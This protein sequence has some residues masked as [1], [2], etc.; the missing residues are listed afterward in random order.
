M[1]YL[2]SVRESLKA[3]MIEWPIHNIR[4]SGEARL[5]LAQ[6]VD[7]AL[8]AAA[9]FPDNCNWS[10]YVENYEDL[11]HMKESEAIGHWIDHGIAEGRDCTCRPR[12]LPD[13]CNWKCYLDNYADLSNL[14][15]TENT[16]VSHYLNHGIDEERDCSCPA[17]FRAKTANDTAAICVIASEEEKYIDEWLDFHLGIGFNH[18]YVYDNTDGFD[19]GHGWLARRPRLAKKV[20]VHHFPGDGKQLSAYR[21]CLKNYVRPDGHGWVAFLDVDEFFMLKKHASVIEF[22]L[23]HCKKGSVSL[24]WQLFGYDERMDFS[25][26]PVTQRFQGQV[27][28]RENIH[29]KSISN[30]DAIQP[31]QPNNPHYVHLVYGHQQLDTNGDVV[32]NKW[33]NEARP[34]D[35]AVIYHFHTK[36]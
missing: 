8:D 16:A 2:R 12:G 27:F 30:V 13:G 20:T 7:S 26:K 11:Q 25:P 21:H 4:G 10:C 3:E 24:N 36:R 23:D 14:E 15:R 22:L 28:S 17:T 32:E 35:V 9:E 31:G 18:I 1:L 6:L 5:P 33:S 29:V 34:T 19:L